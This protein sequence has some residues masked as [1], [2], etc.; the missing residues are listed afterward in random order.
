MLSVREIPDGKASACM[1]LV[2]AA[3]YL[4]SF[5]EGKEPCADWKEKLPDFFQQESIVILRK[6]KRSEKE[7]DIR[8]GFIIGNF[9][10]KRFS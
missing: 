7:T 4:V 6:T 9:R 5:R 8:P 10:E 3:D 1:S 2:A